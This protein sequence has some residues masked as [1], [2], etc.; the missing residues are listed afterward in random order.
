MSKATKIKQ[1]LLT[2]TAEAIEAECSEGIYVKGSYSAEYA[3]ILGTWSEMMAY[4]LV[5]DGLHTMPE[6][7]K[8]AEAVGDDLCELMIFACWATELLDPT[9]C[10]EH[11]VLAYR[12]HLLASSRK[13]LLKLK[14]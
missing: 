12:S 9:L 8:E 6:K 14:K 3:W 13:V 4:L 7:V 11:Q 10:Y 1:Q 5:N 2:K